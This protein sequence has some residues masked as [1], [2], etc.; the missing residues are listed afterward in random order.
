MVIPI[1][2]PTTRVTARS[3]RRAGGVIQ[4]ARYL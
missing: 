3:A 4:V 1:A 2:M